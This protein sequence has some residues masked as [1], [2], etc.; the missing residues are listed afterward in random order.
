M[1]VAVDRQAGDLALGWV[2]RAGSR[3]ARIRPGQGLGVLECAIHVHQE[4]F[5]VP[6]CRGLVGVADGGARAAG[7]LLARRVGAACYRSDGK[8]DKRVSVGHQH[9][10]IVAVCGRRGG[11]GSAVRTGPDI[12]VVGR[13]CHVIDQQGGCAVGGVLEHLCRGSGDGLRD[14]FPVQVGAAGDRPDGD[15]FERLYPPSAGPH[16]QVPVRVRG[17]EPIGRAGQVGAEVDAPAQRPGVGPGIAE[18]EGL[19]FVVLHVHLFLFA[20]AEAAQAHIGGVECLFR[21]EYCLLSESDLL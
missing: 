6:V 8:L 19:L 20:D 2:G 18:G 4:D 10:A 16:Q 14:R 13:A 1:A 12:R 5:G 17:D 21:A 9:P 7:D 15:L 11:R 3:C